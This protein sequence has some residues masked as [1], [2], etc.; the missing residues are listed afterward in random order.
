M[1]LRVEM[2]QNL[3][4]ALPQGASVGVALLEIEDAILEDGGINTECFTLLLDLFRTACVNNW[5]SISDLAL[6]FYNQVFL[7]LEEQKIALSQV[8]MSVF[9][10]L[11]DEGECFSIIEL[12]GVCCDP[13][14]FVS[15]VQSAKMSD[16]KLSFVPRGCI[17]LAKREN[18][19]IEPILGLLG[20]IAKSP[21]LDVRREAE[22]ALIKIR[23]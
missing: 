7:I 4:S 2:I 1:I 6:F 15:W 9:P 20:R 19:F 5:T 22:Y 8:A 10:K 11:E 16:D 14:E 23:S 21:D 18:A 3:S 13:K 12:I 17:K